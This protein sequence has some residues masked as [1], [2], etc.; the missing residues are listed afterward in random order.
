MDELTYG[1]DRGAI[2]PLGDE[3][4]AEV[5]GAREHPDERHQARN[6]APDH[7]RPRDASACDLSDSS[8]DDAGASGNAG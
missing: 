2:G 4:I 3:A 5:E 1:D 8:I 7:D 6:R